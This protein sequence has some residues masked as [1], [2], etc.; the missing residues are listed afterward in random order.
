MNKG[1]R[2]K[3][4]VCDDSVL[5]TYQSASAAAVG[6]KKNDAL[7]AYSRPIRIGPVDMPWHLRQREKRRVGSVLYIPKRMPVRTHF[8]HREKRCDNS[9]LKT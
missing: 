4:D 2:E 3:S 8:R 7:I 5:K 9:V 1:G 6:T